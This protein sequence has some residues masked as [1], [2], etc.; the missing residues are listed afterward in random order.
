MFRLAFNL[1]ADAIRSNISSH[2]R[3]RAT[4]HAHSHAGAHASLHVRAVL[5]IALLLAF[6][7]MT[8]AV[9]AGCQAAAPEAATDPGSSAAAASGTPAATPETT[10]EPGQ[11][12]ALTARTSGPVEVFTAPDDMPFTTL[13]AQTRFGTQTVLLVTATETHDGAEWLE[14]LL[15]VRPNGATGWVH[16]DQVEQREVAL[17]VEIDLEAR[18]LTLLQAGET[19][20][21]TPTAIGDA[22][23]P[24]PIGT[25]FVTDKLETGDAASSY[26]PYAIGLSAR[27][28]VLTEF[29]GGDG[30][31][32]IHGTNEPASIGQ[33]A[34]HGCLRIDNDLVAELA[35]V[36]P[37][38]TPVTIS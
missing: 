32:G 9:M 4:A 10:A 13:D 20:W 17:A 26:G 34:S 12:I 30:Q 11:G 37:L 1:V 14:V 24:T 23:H 25:F 6:A 28:D 16:A 8:I 2:G 15:P 19:L 27:S 36:L 22:D 3:D 33:A 31:V 29:A 18:E 5:R 38:G 7:I 21:S 35:H